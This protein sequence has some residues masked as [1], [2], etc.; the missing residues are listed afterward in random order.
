M[1]VNKWGSSVSN[2]GQLSSPYGMCM[3]FVYVSEG[4]NNRIGMFEKK[5]ATIA[6]RRVCGWKVCVCE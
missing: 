6:V 5:W 2:H 4:S 3:V 1:F